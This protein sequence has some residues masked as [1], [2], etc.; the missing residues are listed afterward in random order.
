MRGQRE[1]REGDQE[2]TAADHAWTKL[3]RSVHVQESCIGRNKRTLGVLKTECGAGGI[4]ED[5]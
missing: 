5:S 4:K 1:S 2:V 3:V